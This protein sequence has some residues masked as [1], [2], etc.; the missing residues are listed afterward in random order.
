MSCPLHS[1]PNHH[2]SHIHLQGQM[3]VREMLVWGIKSLKASFP[4]YCLAWMPERLRRGIQAW[5]QIRVLCP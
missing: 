1:P 5:A 4:Q 3:Q 2:L